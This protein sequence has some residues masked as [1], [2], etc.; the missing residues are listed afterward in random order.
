MRG[1]SVDFVQVVRREARNGRVEITPDFVVGRSKDLMIRGKSFYAIWDEEAGLWSTDEYDVQRLVDLELAKYEAPDVTVKYMRSYKNNGWAEFKRFISQLSDNSHQLDAKLT[2]ANDDV[3]KRD[4]VSKRLPYSIVEGPYDAWDELVGALYSP[5][6][7]QK[8]EWSIG[9]IVSGDSK[10]IQ[11]FVVLH[12]LAGTGKS[13]I[14]NVIEQLFQGYTTYFEAKALGSNN[15][16]FAMEPFRSNPLV[17]IQ[18]DG[19]LSRIEDNTR[20]NSIIAHEAMTMNEKYK[21]SYSTSIMAFLYMGTNLPVKISDAKSGMIRRLIDVT[22]TGILIPTRRYNDLMRQIEFELGAIAYHCLTVYKELGRSYYNGY[23]P[24]SMM[25]KTDVFFNFVEAHW[26][27]FTAQDGVSLKQAYSLYRTYCDETGIDKQRL[28]QYRMREEL[29]NYFDEFHD[30]A[31][32]DGETHRSYYTGFKRSVIEKG[33]KQVA[34]VADPTVLSFKETESLLNEVL[35]GYAAQY[36]KPDGTPAKYWDDSPRIINGELRTPDIKF[37]VNTTLSEID[38]SKLHYVKPPENLVVIDFDLKDSDGQKCARRNIEESSKWPPTYGEISAGGNGVHL[39]YYWDGDTSLLRRDYSDGIEVKIFGGNAALR[40]RVSKCNAL[41]IATI[42]SGL[43]LKEK[44]AVLGVDKVRSERGLRDLIKRN[45]RKEIH[46]GT[47]PSVDFIQHILDEAY[48]SG[49]QY[50]VTDMRS[51]IIAF[52]NSSTHHGLDCLRTTMLMKYR[53]EEAPE[54]PLEAPESPVDGR[55]VF[56]DVEVYPNLFVV[57]WKYSG[58]SNVVAM[59]DPSA[60]DVER[61]FKLKL[62]GFNNR[63]YDNHMLYARYMGYDNERLYRLSQ[64]IIDGDNSGM[65]GEAYRLSYTDIYDF[66]SKKQSLKKFQIDLGIRHLEMALPWDQPVKEE[67]VPKV[68]E[69]CKN[70]VVST[71]AVF[72]SRKQD[73]IAREILAEL[74]G[75]TANDTTAKHT[76]AIIFGG[77]RQPQR[78]FKYTRLASMFEGYKYERGTSTYKDEVV[79]E[80]GYVYAEP[81]IYENVALL[82][83]AS[84]HP[85][86]I[87][88]LG[89]FGDYTGRF[90]ELV[91]AR[92]AIKHGNVEGLRDILGG[93]LSKFV[94]S[95]ESGLRGLAYALKTVINIVYGLTSAKFDNPFRDPRNVDNIVAKRGA[96]FM[97]DLKRAIQERGFTVAHIKTDSVKIPNAT[98]EIIQFVTDFGAKYGYTFEHEATYDRFCLVND[99][100][101]VAKQGDAWTTVGAQFQHPYVYKRLFSGEQIKFDD[102]CEAKSV[103]QGSMYMDFD[104]DKPI[105]CAEDLERMRFV[106]RSGL[107]VPVCEGFGGARLYRVKEGKHY[108]V[109]GTKGYVW[110]EAEIARGPSNEA[111]DYTYFEDL[112]KAARRQIEK[113][114]NFEKFVE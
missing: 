40:R 88:E 101:Y 57:C 62:I 79:G 25:F 44:R 85:T 55:L 2:F 30:R 19:D 109:T 17:G 107:F 112:C 53:S 59:I 37:V 75:L 90:A 80:G 113:F 111:I 86:S 3:K 7:R 28:P 38:A 61:L 31:T 73:F 51:A 92:L 6:E 35:A 108:A 103:A 76:A 77:D 60:E 95:D 91:Q 45:L 20:L 99:A 64:R 15:G 29:R 96:L 39:H 21:P 65:F 27:I 102:L 93:K 11:K 22:P 4:Y 110:V 33:S 48:T 78:Q 56:F 32:I 54:A 100:V 97:I 36:A 24:L 74:S 13:T 106:G 47:K 104:Y 81:G 83:V 89:L 50:D 10:K 68:V 9:A 63:R 43:P 67:D 49:M 84:M 12:G 71:E 87:I 26:D 72:V 94:S 69:Y 41:P 58:D 1:G 42:N 114:G 8:I 16:S 66:S 98:P 82:D 105:N 70:D 18:H 52:A 5:E 34:L 23:R 46:P 14:F